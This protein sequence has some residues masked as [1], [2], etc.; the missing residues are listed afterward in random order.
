MARGSEREKTPASRSRALLDRVTRC[1]HRLRFAVVFACDVLIGMRACSPPLPRRGGGRRALSWLRLFARPGCAKQRC[2]GG[3]RC[4][5]G[6]RERL[7]MPPIA[8]RA[9]TLRG[10]LS[11]ASSME[12]CGIALSSDRV[13]RA[14]ASATRRDRMGA[15][16]VSLPNAAPS[17]D[18]WRWPAS[19]SARRASRAAHARSLRER[20]R[21]PASTEPSLRSCRVSLF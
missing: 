15:G 10:Q 9:S 3:Q 20:T 12:C 18:R 11:T 6:G 2:G 7:S 13:G 16:P 17:T 19:R 14:R 4:W 8:L 21:P 1:D 5:P